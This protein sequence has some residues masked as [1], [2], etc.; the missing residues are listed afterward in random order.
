ML[1]QS[2]SYTD[3]DENDTTETLYFNLTKTELADNLDLEDEL[4]EIQKDFTG[5]GNRTLEKHEIRRVLELVKTFMRLS[6]GVRS[7]DGKRFIKTDQ[8]WEE[9]TQTAAYDAFLFSLFQE[10]EK[11]FAFM[12]GILPKDARDA[13]LKAAEKDG[14]SDDLR[15]AA[16]L[17][18]QGEQR[19]KAEAAAAAKQE[20][21][22]HQVKPQLVG[23]ETP[24][25][26][27]QPTLSTP[28]TQDEL[29]RMTEWMERQK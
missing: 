19:E 7:S 13:A 25:E 15:R 14:I 12:I 1:K 23:L 16:V 2:V 22:I 9:F 28:P 3:F 10:P 11:A 27:P 18:A 26:D 6:Y 20:N 5:Q 29:T 24:S 21:P 17:A 8:I 4:K